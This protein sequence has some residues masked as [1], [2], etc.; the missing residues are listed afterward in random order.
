MTHPPGFHPAADV[1]VGMA[2]IFFRL[3]HW[4]AYTGRVALRATSGLETDRAGLVAAPQR[5]H[6]SG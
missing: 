2:R 1:V 3:G 6:L 5:G 4:R